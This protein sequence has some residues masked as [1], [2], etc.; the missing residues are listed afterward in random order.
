[1]VRTGTIVTI[2]GAALAV[3][4]GVTAAVPSASA[5]LELVWSDE[6][7]R[8]GAPDPAKWTP[9]VGRVRNGEAQY[10]TSGRRENARV[11]GGHLVLEAR[12]EA[13]EGAEFTSAS[14]TTARSAGWTYGR[15]EVR[16][17]IPSGRG[18]WPAIWMLGDA[19]RW[20]G[21]PACGEID[22]MENV[23]YDHDIIH[24]TVH[25]GA[26][27]HPMKTQKGGSVRVVKPSADF[28]IYAVDWTAEAMIFTFD[29]REVFRFTNEKTGPAAWP[30][31][32][33]HY[34]L[35]N[36]AVGGGWGGQQ[37]I[38]DAVFP[39]RMLVDYVRVYQRPVIGLRPA[40]RPAP[41]FKAAPPSKKKGVGHWG[42]RHGGDLAAVG[43][44]WYYNWGPRSGLTNP[45]RAEFVPMIWGMNNVNDADFAAVKAAKPPVLL[46]FNEPDMDGQ[47]EMTVAQAVEAWPRLEA[48][49]AKRLGSPG[50]T[51]WSKWTDEFMAQAKAK[52][53]KV[54]ILCLHWYG[55][56]T[57]PG[58][59][60]ELHA[61]LEHYWKT[62]R[63]PIWLT[64]YSGGD[65]D[66]H[67]RKTTVE[68]N[69]RFARDSVALLE[70]LPY[71]ERYA[72]FAPRVSREDKYYPT[73]ALV[74]DGD[75]LTT[76]GVAYRDAAAREGGGLAFRTYDGEWNVLPGF[77]KLT[78]TTTGVAWGIGTA[79]RLG[80]NFAVVLEG[81]I[82]IPRDGVWTFFTES[83]DGSGL[84][85]GGVK[86]VANDGRHET[87]ERSG[88]I[89]LA[90]GLHRIRVEYFQ[91][92]K[93]G[94]LGASWEGPGVPKEPIPATAFLRP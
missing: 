68:D 16:A 31:D 89:G 39:Q 44:H 82:E 15:I 29:G 61:Y 42:R 59:V 41:A 9:E 13:F 75:R 19:I 85:I 10:Y 2:L 37:G 20:D 34:L 3:A 91:A 65:F 30:F 56:I 38:D 35:L 64:E 27:N 32:A 81:F 88:R 48:T 94:S 93:S 17:K 28:H 78:A 7:D 23:G 76:V 22:I 45:V 40:D 58:P 8:D 74:G 4:A 25:T 83:D 70:S 71:V 69:A 50:A 84:F 80:N 72:W 46:G 60:S 53:L 47:A 54:D 11:E 79:G 36:V 77:A 33:P 51:T 55:D 52:R 43:A 86:V 26:Y 24:C 12:K 1:M 21:W 62:Y 49:G 92:G 18:L 67:R 5:G 57:A 90:K 87:A 66:D 6:F 73:V 63:L 14:L